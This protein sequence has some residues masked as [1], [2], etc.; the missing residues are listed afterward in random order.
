VQLSGT[1]FAAYTARGGFDQWFKS[2]TLS[3]DG[4][5]KVRVET[6]TEAH[7]K[8]H[9][10]VPKHRTGSRANLL[11]QNHSTLETMQVFLDGAPLRTLTHIPKSSSDVSL[12]ATA[13]G[14]VPNAN[15]QG[16]TDSLRIT[17]PHL[18]LTIWT[19]SAIVQESDSQHLKYSHL[20]LQIDGELPKGSTGL[21]AD[22]ASQVA[23][24]KQ[25]TDASKVLLSVPPKV[26][27]ARKFFRK[28]NNALKQ[29][30]PHYP[31]LPP[32][33]QLNRTIVAKTSSEIE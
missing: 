9:P 31:L 30:L 26:V 18:N 19:V 25:L 1:T 17:S 2:F 10:V 8:M 22:L 16:S 23:T 29:A 27:E 33:S 7:T 14:K 13:G 4:A 24:G 15:R 3:I 6:Q 5:A 32:D 28:A 12:R 11:S 20:N 21:L